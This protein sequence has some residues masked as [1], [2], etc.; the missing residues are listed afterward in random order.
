[1]VAIET[2]A[3]RCLALVVV[4]VV[5]CAAPPPPPP[6]VTP[7][8]TPPPSFRAV[9]W[10]EVVRNDP[11]ITRPPVP[12]LANVA[13]LFIE[14]RDVTTTGLLG[15]RGFVDT[16]NPL[17]GDFSGDGREE[18][19]IAVGDPAVG[20]TGFLIY[21]A[22]DRGPQLTATITGRA[23]RATIANGEL[24]VTDG[25]F[26]GWEPACCPNLLRETR[27]RLQ[28]TTLRP[29]ARVE[30]P[31]LDTRGLAVARYYNSMNQGNWQDAWASLSPELQAA[32]SREQWQAEQERNLPFDVTVRNDV[33]QPAVA[34]DVITRNGQPDGRRFTGTWT[35]QFDNA[36][37]VWLLQ[38]FTP[39]P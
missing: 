36:R 29:I 2:F 9:R 19:V 13:G 38:R 32:Q 17:Y 5:G 22:S 4:V 23:M 15:V 8:P 27:Y 26:A 11:N 12:N 30:R 34:V 37:R 10:D 7:S 18:A 6:G 33:A 3:R 31:N 14:T 24:I 1:M 39:T 21:R 28:E 16:T 35:V 25:L 20:I